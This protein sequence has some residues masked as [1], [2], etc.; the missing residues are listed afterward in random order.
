MSKKDSLTHHMKVMHEQ[1]ERRVCHI[2]GD[3]FTSI[4][5]FR[6]HLRTHSD[7]VEPKV[8]SD[9]AKCPICGIEFTLNT[10]I[11]KHLKTHRTTASR[12]LQSLCEQ[13]TNST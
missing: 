10:T 8:Y 7:V 5:E 9:A 4:R 6:Q 11:S 3:E 12:R 13:K 1:R 2:C